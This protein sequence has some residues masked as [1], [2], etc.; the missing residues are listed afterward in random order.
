MK[1]NEDNKLRIYKEWYC[2]GNCYV[3]CIREYEDGSAMIISSHN[4][5]KNFDNLKQ[6]ISY[7]KLL[8]FRVP[9]I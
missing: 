6:A 9:Y 4:K 3:S 7:L 1:T 8:A 5:Y 2:Y